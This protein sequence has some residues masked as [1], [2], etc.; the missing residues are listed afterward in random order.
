MR[1]QQPGNIPGEVNAR[2]YA[3]RASVG[4]LLVTEATQISQR[5][6]GYPATPGIHSSE[7]IAGW[8]LVTDG[9]HAKGGLIFLQLWHVGRISH[10]SHQPDGRL[11]LA[12]SAVKPA[13]DAL[14]ASWEKAPFETP[15]EVG[16]DEIPS[17][18]GEYR[19]AASNAL[20]AGFDGV[21]LHAAN[22]Y[23]LDQFLRDGTNRRTDRYGGSFENRARLL[24]EV[25]DAVG[26]VFGLN[27][28]GIR[29]SPLGTFNDMRDS[30]PVGIFSHVLRALAKRSIAYVH[31][32]EARGDE[33]ALDEGLPLDSGAAPT[34]ALFRPFYPGVL[35]G[36]GGFTRESADEA[37][38]AGTVDAVAFG[39][40]FISNPDLP[41]RLKLDAELNSYDRTTFYGGAAQGYTDYATLEDL[42]ASESQVSELIVELAIDQIG[43]SKRPQDVFLQCLRQIFARN[44][45][46]GVASVDWEVV[47]LLKTRH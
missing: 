30:D 47:R 42:R 45:L 12:P 22:G 24:L 18:V 9:V 8:R 44:I 29:L 32:I 20:A 23:L 11:P 21:E 41:L 34:A 46:G 7:Q 37:I 36:A 6:Q 2:Y 15:R 33:R 10:R 43:L 1:A 26:E 19:G 40:L 35:I 17:L 38:A 28:V 5:G 16:L 3:Q 14:T 13:G 27:R 39:R 31:L 25:L 4:G